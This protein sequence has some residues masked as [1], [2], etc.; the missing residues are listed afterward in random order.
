MKSK[1]FQTF[2]AI[3][4]LYFTIIKYLQFFKNE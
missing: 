2:D 4:A 1:N 3:Y